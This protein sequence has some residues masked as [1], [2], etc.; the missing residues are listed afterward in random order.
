MAQW[1]R[2]L[3]ALQRAHVLFPYL[4]GGSQLL[5]MTIVLGNLTPSSGLYSNRDTGKQTSNQYCNM[6]WFT[7]CSSRNV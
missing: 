4:L 6:T 2:T 7:K 3:A 5:M 1:V